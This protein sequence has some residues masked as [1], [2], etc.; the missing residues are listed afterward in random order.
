MLTMRP[1]RFC[2]TI[3]RLAARVRRNVPRRFTAR[4]RSHT[5]GSGS[6]PRPLAPV[7]AELRRMSRRPRRASVSATAR[8]QSSGSLTSPATVASAPR[9][10]A[11]P[12]SS[13]RSALWSKTATRAPAAIQPAAAAR[14]IPDAPPLTS[15]T[16]PAKLQVMSAMVPRLL[17]S[18]S[19]LPPGGAAP[20]VPRHGDPPRRVGDHPDGRGPPPPAPR[21]QRPLGPPRRGRRARGVGHRG[22][23]PRGARGDGPRGDAAQ[24][25][26]R[27]LRPRARP[28]RHLPRRQRHPLR[29]LKLRVPRRRRRARLPPGGAGTGL[30][31]PRAAPGGDGADAPGADRRRARAAGG[32]VRAV[33]LLAAAVVALVASGAWAAP[34]QRFFVMGDGTLAIVNAHTGERAEVQYRRAD[35]TY[36]QAA[37]A[38]IRRAFRSSGD[39]GEGRASL[40]LIEVLSWA[41]KTARA[42]PLT[43]MSGYRRPEYNEGLRA[44]GM[45]AAAGSLHTEG[46]AADVAFPR[47]VL[48]P[49]GMKVRA[50]DCCGAGYYA[51]EGFLHIDVGK[52]RFWE[53]STS[54]V[55]ENLSAGNARLFAGTEFDR[56]ARGEEIVVALHAMTVAP[57]RVGREVRI[58]P[59]RGE[60]VT[61]AVGGELVERDGCLGVASGGSVRREA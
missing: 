59:E 14:P 56:Y 25:H 3:H 43:L 7:P 55:G 20:T 23:G 39:E 53:P 37:L 13:S 51:K 50:L 58:V 46:L 40:R 45:R 48:R 54:R 12:V 22:A 38:R 15:A 41:Q 34:L 8:S 29:Q 18:R 57:V 21:R 11:P 6:P 44:K 26:R 16:L 36:D 10:S 24:T 35:G 60:A 28:G 2:S 9:P 1:G 61:I 47:A 42:R 52:P 31:R 17:Q 49:L 5:R 19:R 30:A 4:T 33:R 27:L 32:G